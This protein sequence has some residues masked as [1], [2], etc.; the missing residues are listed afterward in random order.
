[1]VRLHAQLSRYRAAFAEQIQPVVIAF[2]VAG[3]TGG[4]LSA[5]G[6]VAG[7]AQARAQRGGARSLWPSA[8]GS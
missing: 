8:P 1:M 3:M 6:L 5:L 4:A 2:S 7:H